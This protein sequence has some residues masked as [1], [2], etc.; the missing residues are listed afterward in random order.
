MKALTI[1]EIKQ[2][3]EDEW[4]Y[5]VDIKNKEESSYYKFNRVESC[6]IVFHE[7][8]GS[9]CPKCFLIDNYSKTWLAYKNKEQAECKGVLVEFACN[10]GDIIYIPWAYDETYGIAKYAVK[11]IDFCGQ[12]AIYHTDFEND[13]EDKYLLYKCDNGDFNTYNFNEIWFIDKEQAE[14]KLKELRGKNE[15]KDRH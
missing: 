13:I 2:L 9:F 12:L 15:G 1:E 3:K 14:Q 7:Q 4:V 6:F 10:I 5:I 11:H 8:D